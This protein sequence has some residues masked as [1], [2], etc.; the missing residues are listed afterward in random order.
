MAQGNGQTT[1]CIAE[2]TIEPFDEGNPGPHVTEAIKAVEETGLAVTVGPF[3][4]SIEGTHAQVQK[5]VAAALGAGLT[6][7]ASR[8]TITVARPDPAFPTASGPLT[9]P[10]IMVARSDP[11]SP[12]DDLHPVIEALMP[13]FRAVG[14]EPVASEHM[15]R[16]D[17]PI[18]WDGEVVGGVRMQS[19]EGVLGRMVDQITADLDRDLADLNREEKQQVVRILNE[20]GAFAIRG[21]VE[22]VGDMLGVSRITIYNYLNATKT[23]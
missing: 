19:L 10:A 7:G 6:E 16:T 12:A 17:V 11:A 4:T 13:V 1:S 15:C 23:A 2:F 9:P 3:G 14:A 8:V 22:E 18:R 20:R 21:A 5:A